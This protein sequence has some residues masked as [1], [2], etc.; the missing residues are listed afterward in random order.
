MP[1]APVWDCR[2]EKEAYRIMDEKELWE[3]LTEEL[4]REWEI[5]PMGGGFTVMTDWHWPNGNRIEIYAR[6]VGDRDDLYVVTDGGELFSFLFSQGVDLTR[7]ERSMRALERTVEDQGGKLVELQIVKGTGR[8][9]LPQTIRTV[10][11][12]LKDGSFMMW[13]KFQEAAGI[14]H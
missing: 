14:L 10:L 2:A 3:S 8:N 6:T 9:E 11:E 7:D 5:I 13:H 12:I 4:V 1:A